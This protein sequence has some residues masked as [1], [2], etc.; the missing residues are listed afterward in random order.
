MTRAPGVR[1]P[2]AVGVG[3]VLLATTACTAGPS[4]DPADDVTATSTADG[5]RGPGATDSTSGV[6]DEEP[7]PETSSGEDDE[8]T[9]TPPGPPARADAPEVTSLSRAPT[10][11]PLVARAGWQVVG[12]AGACVLS[13]RGAN[14]AQAPTAG[15]REASTT[16]LAETVGADG[17]EQ[18][19]KR[20]VLLP[21]ASDGAT[22]QGMNAV[23]QDWTVDTPRGRVQVRGAARVASVPTYDGGASAQSVV[24]ALD[25]AGPLDDGV[26]EQ[27]LADVRV[28]FVG[29]VE[30]LGAWPS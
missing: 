28:G 27:L 18:T 8:A 14:D 15:A 20:D 1:A 26:W 10:S 5:A 24:L 22:V 29:P 13:W 9:G 30:E 12:A 4:P 23:A 2:L 21:L 16:L 19:A 25:C 7:E 17:G 6:P 3:L 11:A